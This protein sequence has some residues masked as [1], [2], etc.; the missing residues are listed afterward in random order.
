MKSKISICFLTIVVILLALVMIE[1][2]IRKELQTRL[3]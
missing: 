2:S 3:L 1:K